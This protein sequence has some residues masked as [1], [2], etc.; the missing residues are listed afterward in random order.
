MNGART[1]TG[2]AGANGF[3]FALVT[4]DVS[5]TAVTGTVT[6]RVPDGNA[7]IWDSATSQWID[8]TPSMSIDDLTDVNTTSTAPTDGQV[9]TWDN[10]ASNWAPADTVATLSELGGVDITTVAP[11]AGDLLIYDGTSTNFE[12]GTL[13]SND[14]SDVDTS[15]TPTDRDVLVYSS[16]SS[17]FEAGTLNIDDLADVDTTTS[18][19]SDGEVLV[20]NTSSS[21]WIP[22]VAAAELQTT[23]FFYTAPAAPTSTVSSS[24]LAGQNLGSFDEC[25]FA[26][27]SSLLI[28]G[29]NAVGGDP[30][31][32][33]ITF[34][35]TT[36]L[37]QNIPT[38]RYVLS[39]SL[40][41]YIN[42]PTALL[43]S[44]DLL[45]LLALTD[46]GSGYYFQDIS[47]GLLPYTSYGSAQAAIT[48]VYSFTATFDDIAANNTFGIFLDQDQGPSY[49]LNACDVNFVR[50]GDV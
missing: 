18:A 40:I 39:G 35:G 31:L 44:P 15:T 33:G 24:A 16:T 13:S 20:W 1:I 17:N 30:N 43:T 50:L 27:R 36:G 6:P 26:N 37:F 19:P 38:G 4:A 47:F 45:V 11:T 23:S 22:G 29:P 10:A 49:Y 46:S 3:T 5:S 12:P 9:L 7:L 25:T 28:P 42:N 41:L 14:L 48:A 21:A 32:T 2:L 8:G 34:N